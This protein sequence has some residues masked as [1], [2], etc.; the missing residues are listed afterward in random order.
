[1]STKADSMNPGALYR[2]YDT[3]PTEWELV[4]TTDSTVVG[5]PARQT[6]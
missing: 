4:E 1:M 6:W 3:L 5:G 2:V